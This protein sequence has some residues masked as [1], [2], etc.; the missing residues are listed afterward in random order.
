MVA[1]VADA[2]NLRRRRPR[3]RT[4]RNERASDNIRV[5]CCAGAMMEFLDGLAANCANALTWYRAEHVVM[6]RLR[7]ITVRILILLAVCTHDCLGSG[8]FVGE[9]PATGATPAPAVTKSAPAPEPQIASQPAA[10]VPAPAMEPGASQAGVPTAVPAMPTSPALR[11]QPDFAAP[12]SSP[13]QAPVATAPALDLNGLEQRLRDTHAIGLFTKLSLKN[14]VDDLLA[15]FK[16][17][18]Q[19][20]PGISLEQLRQKY[21]LLLMRV[22]SLLQD[23]DPA[24]ASAVFSSRQAIWGV[25]I[26]PKK[27]AA[28]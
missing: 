7:V 23:G 25:L 4:S 9:P 21:E 2:S 3:A 12:A 26:D 5:A 19:G 10:A 18:H 11:S 8:A 16:A 20:Q 15:Q 13:S 24:L 22:V 17:F 27:F 1:S 14:Q 28:I 6:A